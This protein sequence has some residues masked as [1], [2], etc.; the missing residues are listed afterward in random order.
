MVACSIAG[1]SA[2]GAELSAKEIVDKALERN[3]FGFENAV[4]R[5]K[6]TLKSKSGSERLRQV[7]IR[8]RD[9]DG[10]AR[11]L[12]RFDSPA[13][14]AGTGFLVLEKKEGDDDQYLYLPALGKVK[15]ISG[16][17]RNQ[18][19]MGTDLTYADLE[20]RDLRRA[21]LQRLADATVG[22]QPTYVIEARPHAEEDSAYGK[23]ITWIHKENFV[24]VKV[25][26][27]DK[28]LK[29]LKTLTVKRLSKKDGRW[30]ATETLIA[31][32]SGS[33]TLM[34][35]LELSFGVK[36]GDDEFT[37]RALVGG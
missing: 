27:F 2:W 15:R 37:E 20:W 32:E 33:Q 8:S 23:T 1:A 28:K 7:Q 30:V 5:V 6:L 34:Q 29:L 31:D 26:F 17:Q 21:S 22:K 10:L 19:F 9:K 25:Q 24:P 3:A 36:L 16:S 14:V 11:T 13:D 4:A 12:V 18:K 35:V